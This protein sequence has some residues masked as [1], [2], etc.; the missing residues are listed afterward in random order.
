MLLK[1]S[2]RDP[3]A[4]MLLMELLNQAGMPAGVTNVVHGS[5][6]T[7]DFLCENSR[8]RAIS[9]VGSNQAGEYIHARGTQHGKRV[10]VRS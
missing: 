2:E 3:G 8:I 5:R 4:V 9:F 10:Q 6:P 7:V 1:P